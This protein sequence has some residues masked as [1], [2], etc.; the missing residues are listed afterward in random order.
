[1]AM[2]LMILGRS[3]KCLIKMEN[4]LYNVLS[5]VSRMKKRV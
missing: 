3:S 1:M 2:Y 5:K 4:K